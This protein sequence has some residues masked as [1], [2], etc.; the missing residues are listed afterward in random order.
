MGMAALLM[1]PNLF[2][3][4]AS[5]IAAQHCFTTEVLKTGS[6]A[7]AKLSSEM[8][9]VL[10]VSKQAAGIRLETLGLL[11]PARQPWLIHE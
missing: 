6:A 2:R 1:P 3:P 9:A 5:K 7:A 8:A 4:L 10:D 11:S